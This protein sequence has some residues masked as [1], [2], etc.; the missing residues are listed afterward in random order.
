MANWASILIAIGFIGVYA[1][2][3]S[4]ETRQLADALTA[5]ELA[6]A[7]E[8]H[9]SQLDGLAAAA[10]HELATPLSTIMVVAKELERSLPPDSPYAEDVH[11]LREQAQ[12]CRDILGKLTELDASGAPFDQMKLS[13]LLEEVVAPHRNF[14]IDI[15][16]VLPA[17]GRPRA[18]QHAQPG[19]PLRPRQPARERGRFR[20][21]AGRG[22]GALDQSGGRGHDRRRWAGVFARDQGTISAILT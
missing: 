14:G 20:E 17:N 19:D 18:G 4:E 12:R 15:E 7:R 11:L 13:A 8:Q 6:L 21:I 3:I 2:Q 9:L 1:W 5:T 16:V 10:A 22:G